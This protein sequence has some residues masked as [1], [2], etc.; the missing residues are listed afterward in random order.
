MHELCRSLKGDISAALYPGCWGFGALGAAQRPSNLTPESLPCAWPWTWTL[1]LSS[2]C[3]PSALG[4]LK[5][6]CLWLLPAVPCSYLTPLTATGTSLASGHQEPS[7]PHSFCPSLRAGK[8]HIH[9]ISHHR[10]K[11]GSIRKQPEP[12]PVAGP[13]PP[14]SLRACLPPALA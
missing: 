3:S 7:P 11:P 9:Q 6:G 14:Y 12:L 2:V 13:A 5:V 8:L 10:M 4:L 1:P